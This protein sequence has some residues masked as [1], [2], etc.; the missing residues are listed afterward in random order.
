MRRSQHCRLG[1][2][3]CGQSYAAHPQPNRD[4]PPTGSPESLGRPQPLYSLN[5][6]YYS[7]ELSRGSQMPLRHMQGFT[8]S[9]GWNTCLGARE[10]KE[11]P[12]PSPSRPHLILRTSTLKPMRTSELPHGIV[13]RS[14]QPKVLTLMEKKEG[15]FGRDYSQPPWS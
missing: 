2:H 15:Q 12:G 14:L 5:T 13:P 6:W 4:T 9:Q 10:L 3:G 8:T 11:S 7:L 1:T